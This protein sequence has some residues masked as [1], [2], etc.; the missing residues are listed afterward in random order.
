MSSLILDSLEAIPRGEG[1]VHMALGMFDGVH[2]GHQT[3][4]GAAIQSARQSRGRSA[5]L[6]FW[7]HPSRIFKP[8][9]PTE[10]ISTPE[11]KLCLLQQA[12][13]DLIVQKPFDHG[14]ASITADEF[15]GYL[16]KAVPDLAGV[17]IGENFRF[18]SGRQGRV[19][20]LIEKEPA[21]GVQV[22]SAQRIRFNGQP[23]SST[24]IRGNLKIG[25]IAEANPMLG[26]H[27]FSVGEVEEGNHTGRELGF[28]TL[29]LPWNPECKPAYGVYAVKAYRFNPNEDAR[30]APGKR[31]PGVP[32]VANFGLRPT[33]GDLTEPLLELH[34]LA[35]EVEYGPGD[36]IRVEWHKFIR[37]ER[38]FES[39]DQ[40]R[41]QIERDVEA[42]HRYFHLSR[43][44]R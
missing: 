2:R 21:L 40:L 13:V 15:P 38:T 18:G 16:K 36:Q 19:D 24:R 44:A 14:F 1:P 31:I 34:L 11:I 43:S 8:D 33:I 7:P 12:G 39:L 41:G 32:A 4:I 10:M 35:N 30:I 20:D 22:V 25:Q 3:V 5:V 9:H 29:N 28:P 37:S 26:Y 6:T 42:A 17:Y 27:Y 23:I